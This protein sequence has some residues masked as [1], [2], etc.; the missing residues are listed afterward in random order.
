MTDGDTAATSMPVGGWLPRATLTGP[1]PQNTDVVIVGGGLAGCS[2][3]YYLA[4]HG[5]ESVLLERG[6]LNREASGTNAG[7]FHFQIAL[8]QLTAMETDNIRD[9]LL[10]EVR[11]HAEAAEVWSTLERELDGPLEIHTTGGLMVAETAEEL[12]LLRD[13][14]LIEQEAGLDMQVLTGRELRDFAPYLADDLLGASYC[15]QEG[16]ANP[17]LAAPLFAL[18]AVGAG[19]VVRTHAEV[20]SLAVDQ[21]GGTGRFTVTTTAGTIRASR[22]VNAAGAWAAALATQLG[23]QLPIR[24]E[25]LHLNVTEP[26]E[27]MLGPMVQHIGRRLTLKQSETGT[28]II[29]GGWPARPEPAPLRHSTIWESLAGNTAIAMRVVPLLADVRVV[30]TWSGV[31]AFTHDLQPM[32]GE[33]AR[34]PGYHSLMST[35]GFTLS[36]LMARL[37][38]ESMATGRTTLPPTYDVDRVSGHPTTLEE[39]R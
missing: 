2:L 8:H 21:D 27:H 13:K 35:T 20:T 37:L 17:S 19:A 14:L 10:T 22:L 31:M 16:H 4:Q 3:A 32:V 38:A 28:F 24:A 26:R 23:L 18:R 29:G 5:I 15:A 30:R 7:S 11:L 9:R 39:K 1:L 33:S 6:E 12:Q 34:V 25:G 36:P